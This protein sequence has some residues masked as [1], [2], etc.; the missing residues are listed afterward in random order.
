MTGELSTQSAADGGVSHAD[1]EALPGVPLAAQE[2]ERKR[3]RIKDIRMLPRVLTAPLR[4]LPDYLI[5]GAQKS[6]T[7]TLSDYLWQHPSV[8]CAYQKETHFLDR[9]HARGERGFRAF[10]PLRS[11]ML[12]LR[13]AQGVAITGDATPYYLF[14]PQVPTRAKQL[15]PDAKLIAILRD[16]AE[17]A[18]SHF[19]HEVRKGRETL[20]FNDAMR[21]EHQ[22]MDSLDQ[23]MESNAAVSNFEHQHLSYLRRGLYWRQLRR[24]CQHYPR[25]NLL[26]LTTAEL[27][28]EPAAVLARTCEFLG[29]DASRAPRQAIHANRAPQ[30]EELPAEIR[31]RLQ[32]FFAEENRRLE[33]DFGIRFE[34]N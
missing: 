22:I 31:A 1:P 4:V 18:F 5:I 16:P 25:Q 6:G 33:A 7:T 13:K 12:A 27:A 21:R 10:F 11:R 23:L 3:R 17:R 28:R 15:V 8:A 14:H 26:L 20:G 2:Y 30:K 34:T 24:W 32:E 9:Y 29:I 19:Q